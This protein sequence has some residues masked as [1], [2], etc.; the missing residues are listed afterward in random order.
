[1]SLLY[2]ARLMAASVEPIDRTYGHM[3]LESEA[4]LRG[5]L[6]G[7]DNGSISPGQLAPSQEGRKHDSPGE[8]YFRSHKTREPGGEAV[9]S[10]AIDPLGVSGDSS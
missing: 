7:F 2:L 8:A 1:V 3:L 6:D 4:Y 9:L 5:L 10:N